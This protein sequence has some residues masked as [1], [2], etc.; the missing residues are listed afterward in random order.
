MMCEGCK[1]YMSLVEID[2]DR[3]YWTEQLSRTNTELHKKIIYLSSYISILEK[4]IANLN[5]IILLK[6]ISF[7]SRC[8]EHEK[9]NLENL[10]FNKSKKDIDLI[11]NHCL[12]KLKTLCIQLN[13]IVDDFQMEKSK[14]SKIL[15]NKEK[16]LI[17]N[18]NYLQ[19]MVETYREHLFREMTKYN[20]LK[21]W[22]YD[23]L[24]VVR[25]VSDEYIRTNIEEMEKKLNDKIRSKYKT[26]LQHGNTQIKQQDELIRKMQI[27]RRELYSLLKEE[28]LKRNELKEKYEHTLDEVKMQIRRLKQKNQHMETLLRLKS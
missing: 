14:F 6:D 7:A 24:H 25:K 10:T 23:E 26:T 21:R 13:N 15:Q 27:H 28:K 11:P 3:F 9:E 16:Q 4:K 19:E 1:T 8:I 17:E 2:K 22:I 12:R 20:N 5:E 18:S